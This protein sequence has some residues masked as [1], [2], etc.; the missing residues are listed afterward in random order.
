[1]AGAKKPGAASG[2]KAQLK[3]IGD[4]L[5]QQKFDDAAEQA[6]TVLE[7]DAKNYQA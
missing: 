7:A 1:M 6:R 4:A 5:K 3:A 2:V